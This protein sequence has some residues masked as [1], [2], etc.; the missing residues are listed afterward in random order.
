METALEAVAK[1]PAW[2]EEGDFR[3]ASNGIGRGETWSQSTRRPFP[4]SRKYETKDTSPRKVKSKRQRVLNGKNSPS[5]SQTPLARA[6]QQQRSRS[7][8]QTRRNR[9]WGWKQR[10]AVFGFTFLFPLLATVR[11]CSAPSAR[12]PQ[13]SDKP[14]SNQTCFPRG[15]AVA[16]ILRY[17]RR[18]AKRSLFSHYSVRTRFLVSFLT[19]RSTLINSVISQR[20]D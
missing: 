18:E 20:K 9:F 17:S 10:S 11:M 16:I 2:A 12:A 7:R 8:K 6:K 5:R 19:V 15:T 13:F 1:H 14:E 3:D 4:G